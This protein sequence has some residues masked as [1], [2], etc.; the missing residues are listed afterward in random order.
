MFVG[1][2]FLLFGLI[3]WFSCEFGVLMFLFDLLQCVSD[4]CCGG[5]YDVLGWFC[6]LVVVFIGFMLG[7]V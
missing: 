7:V 5:C 3:E 6:L 1:G 4:L 2:V